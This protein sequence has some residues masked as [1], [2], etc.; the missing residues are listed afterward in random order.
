MPT[1]ALVGVGPCRPGG[2]GTGGTG[3]PSQVQCGQRGPLLG[4]SRQTVRSWNRF[5]TAVWTCLPA[6]SWVPVGHLTQPTAFRAVSLARHELSTSQ[7]SSH[8]AWS[9]A[10]GHVVADGPSRGDGAT[11][12]E[13]WCKAEVSRA[14]H[15]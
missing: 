2:T 10:S 5:L 13:G 9:H 1:S 6:S 7:A 11:Q 14:S 4:T 8:R 12:E 3:P 15:P